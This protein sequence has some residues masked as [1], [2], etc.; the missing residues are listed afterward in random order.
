MAENSG[1]GARRER[2]GGLEAVVLSHVSLEAWIVPS[3]GSNLA[4]FSV[5]GKA[6]IDFDP[7]L[8]AK[9]DY[10]GTP[11]LYPTPNRV[12]NGV[13]RWR[14]RDYR[15]V[16]RGTLILEHGLAHSEPWSCGEPVIE[17]DGVRLETWLEF[18][19]GSAVFEAFP[20]AHRLDLEFRLTGRGV[21]ATYT[22]RNEGSEEVPFGFGLHPYFQKLAGENDTFVTLPADAV[23]DATSDLLPTGKLLEVGGT[24]YDLRRPIAVGRLHLDHVFT[25]LRPGEHARIE[26]R[27]LGVTVTLEATPDFTHQ[28]LYT[29]R[30][31]RFFCLE[32]QTCSTDAHN[33]FDRGFVHE[34]GLKTVKPGETH[35]GSVMYSVTK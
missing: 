35:R 6:I 26:Y 28:V 31:E 32:N 16:K 24:I 9:H 10:T 27:G 7:A 18:R 1:S 19:P 20:F 8:L 12:R 30:G 29:P 3:Y 4:R 15:Q 2:V 5:G 23:M 21:T 25:S 13:V 14:G 17:A 34:S 33:L 11:V 22:I